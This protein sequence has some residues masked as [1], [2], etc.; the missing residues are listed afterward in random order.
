MDVELASNTTITSTIDGFA[1]KLAI[2]ICYLRLRDNI[3]MMLVAKMS[4]SFLTFM[5]LALVSG[6]HEIYSRML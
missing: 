6:Y 3:Q 1:A 5:G 2:Q 4:D